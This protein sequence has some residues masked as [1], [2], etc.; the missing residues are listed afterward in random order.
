MGHIYMYWR[1]GML[2]NHIKLEN[3]ITAVFLSQ[4]IK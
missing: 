1:E 4:S 3:K 2:K